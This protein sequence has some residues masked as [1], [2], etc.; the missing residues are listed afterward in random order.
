MTNLITKI[1]NVLFLH[2]CITIILLPAGIAAEEKPLSL[3]TTAVR[4]VFTANVERKL[5]PWLQEEI[6]ETWFE[7]NIPKSCH[8][9]DNVYRYPTDN[10]SVVTRGVQNMLN[11]KRLAAILEVEEFL[12][13]IVRQTGEVLSI[14]AALH[15]LKQ[16]EPLWAK[17]YEWSKPWSMW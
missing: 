2:A 7:G 6:A 11:R 13:V 10:G 14:E 1:L 3:Q 8:I 15:N 16:E 4:Y 9:C 5:H 17:V 12:T